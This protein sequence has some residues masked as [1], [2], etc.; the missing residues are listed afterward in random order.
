MPEVGA[1]RAKKWS[2]IIKTTAAIASYESTPFFG[3][4]YKLLFMPCKYPQARG[5]AG[6]SLQ[7]FLFLRD[8]R[9]LGYVHGNS[10]T[11]GGSRQK[12]VLRG[13]SKPTWQQTDLNDFTS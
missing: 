13:V 6:P 5:A 1:N 8:S 12:G 2:G 11:S 3:T 10:S 7:R 9:K 4:L